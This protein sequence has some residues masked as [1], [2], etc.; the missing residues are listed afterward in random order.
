MKSL[1]GNVDLA[2]SLI[3]SYSVSLSDNCLTLLV[4]TR[5][6]WCGFHRQGGSNYG[7]DYLQPT[8]N[9]FP[10]HQQFNFSDSDSDTNSD[11]GHSY[12]VLVAESEEEETLLNKSC[13]VNQDKDQIEFI[14]YDPVLPRKEILSV[15]V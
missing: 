5:I 9:G 10:V 13:Y 14:F 7:S 12:I 11:L 6:R 15:R 3:S 2:Q 8:K 1:H 4:N